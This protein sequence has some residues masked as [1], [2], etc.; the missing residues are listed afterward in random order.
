SARI[1]FDFSPDWKVLGYAMLLALVGTALVSAAP[2]VRACRHDLQPLLK[3]GEQG[4]V[5][6]RSSVSNGLVVLQLAFS[7]LLLTTAGLAYRSLSVLTTSDLGFDRDKLLLVTIN[8]KAAAP[9]REANAI[10][11]GSM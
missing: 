3:A 10:L 4:V 11:L 9:T 7:V 5:Q 8:T 2:A 1:A 6:G